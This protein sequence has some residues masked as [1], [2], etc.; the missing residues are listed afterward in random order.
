VFT[1]G[2]TF[3]AEQYTTGLND[4]RATYTA[5]HHFAT[6]YLGGGSITSHQHLWR[7]SFF[8]A[9]AGVSIARWLT[10]FLEGRM[11]HIGP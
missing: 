7:P 6:Y 1:L 4:L 5:T 9:A 10:D 11:T 8:D 2:A 3:P